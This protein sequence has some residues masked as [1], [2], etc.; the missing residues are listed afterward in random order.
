M[1][2][3]VLCVCVCVCV[4]VG[5]LFLSKNNF[6]RTHANAHKHTCAHMHT[7][8][9]TAGF[10]ALMVTWTTGA[11]PHSMGTTRGSVMGMSVSTKLRKVAKNRKRMLRRVI[12]MRVV[13]AC[14]DASESGMKNAA[15]ITYSGTFKGQRCE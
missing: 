6:T 14:S 1:C 7:R 2:I 5:S 15:D 10:H 8:T 12:M 9:H 13:R 4:C 3:C 11:T